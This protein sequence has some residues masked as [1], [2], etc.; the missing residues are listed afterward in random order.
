MT[1]DVQQKVVFTAVFVVALLVLEYSQG[2][3]VLPN[4]W[5]AEKSAAAA[6]PQDAIYGM[7][8][9]ARAGDTRTYLDYFSGEMHAQL[10]QII[11]EGSEPTFAAYL[12]S[13][14]R[15]FEGV[16]VSL[17][18]RPSDAEAQVKVEY[19]YRGH[20]EVQGV[21]L[22]REAAGWKI[23]RVANAEQLITPFPFGTAV[24]D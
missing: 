20:N 16:A 1:R 8:E 6:T 23:I 15:A 21:Y 9:A 11:K 3:R 18:N 17:T 7:L 19:I 12:K 14:N 5:F 4:S 10:L 22:R 13:Q 2:W 24:R